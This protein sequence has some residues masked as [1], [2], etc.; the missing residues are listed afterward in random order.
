MVFCDGVLKKPL[1]DQMPPTKSIARK[2]GGLLDPLETDPTG[3][4]IYT[5]AAVSL[6]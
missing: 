2:R 3:C 5:G 4:C 6:A 1:A